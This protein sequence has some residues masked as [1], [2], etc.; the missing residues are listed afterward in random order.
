MDFWVKKFGFGD[1]LQLKKLYGHT[2]SIRFRQNNKKMYTSIANAGFGASQLLPLIVQALVSPPGSL[3]I[4]EQPEIHLNPRLQ[5]ELGDLFVFMA[6]QEQRVIVETH[7]EHLLLRLRRLIAQ[8]EISHDEIA[9]YFIEKTKDTS[10]IK[11]ISIE[12]DGHIDPIKWPKG[13]FEES[14][15]ESLA[16]ATQQLK[17]K[18]MT[19]KWRQ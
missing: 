3:T 16:L 1:W 11:E 2:Y 6:K 10:T 15:K 19:K 7:S 17:N 4:A 13:F 14:L 12:K 8:K 5:C 18:P 9:I